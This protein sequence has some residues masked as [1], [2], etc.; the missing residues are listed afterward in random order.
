MTDDNKTTAMSLG[1][2][3]VLLVGLVAF[4]SGAYLGGEMVYDEAVAERAG[5]YY[6]DKDY[7]KQFRWLKHDD[8]NNR[9]DDLE[10]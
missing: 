7:D 2:L 9:S 3:V 1:F 5:E 10:R 8:N 6:I 4:L